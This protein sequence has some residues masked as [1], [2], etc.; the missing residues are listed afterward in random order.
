MSPSSDVQGRVVENL[1]LRWRKS[2][3]QKT[4]R[5]DW[6]LSN[7]A[8]LC[9]CWHEL[10]K[11]FQHY[12][13]L[14]APNNDSPMFGCFS[15]RQILASRSSFWWSEDRWE[16]TGIDRTQSDYRH[17]TLGENSSWKPNEW[18]QRNRKPQKQKMCCMM[19]A[20]FSLCSSS[21]SVAFSQRCI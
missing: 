18:T 17:E 8:V 14:P 20:E 6:T 7:W 10:T 12:I 21:W 11:L 15:R 4:H 3:F 9:S 13:S 5:S 2:S 1:R 19:F 16:Q